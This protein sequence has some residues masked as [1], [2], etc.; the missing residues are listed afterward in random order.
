MYLGMDYG[1]I[2]TTFV[3]CEISVTWPGGHPEWGTCCPHIN[4][5]GIF[6]FSDIGSND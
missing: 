4:S 3:L 2:F 6:M 1:V 5:R